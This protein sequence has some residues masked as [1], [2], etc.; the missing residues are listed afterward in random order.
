MENQVTNQS[1]IDYIESDNYPLLNLVLVLVQISIT[2]P[3]LIWLTYGVKKLELIYAFSIISTILLVVMWYLRRFIVKLKFE[4]SANRHEL[5]I[6]VC[7]DKM[8]PVTKLLQFN[9]F[10]KKSQEIA[11]VSDYEPGNENTE[12]ESFKAFALLI[13][14]QTVYCENL[15]IKS[16]NLM[17]AI[18]LILLGFT[19]LF[20]FVSVLIFDTSDQIMYNRIALA[21]FIVVFSSSII[22]TF[23]LFEISGKKLK[24]IRLSL[25]EVIANTNIPDGSFKIIVVNEFGN[26]SNAMLHAPEIYNWFFRF[27]KSSIESEWKKIQNRLGSPP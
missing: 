22:E 20:L 6:A 19:L 23:I 7:F 1:A 26:Y 14:R 24:E 2:I 15:H 4:S 9:S 21:T 10:I 27:H 12:I 5:M 16:T 8:I 11:D 17:K 18:F 13:L 25:N 3:A